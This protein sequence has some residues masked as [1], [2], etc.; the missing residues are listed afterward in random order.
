MSIHL[1]FSN[2]EFGRGRNQGT[3]IHQPCPGFGVLFSFPQLLTNSRFSL[4]P[5]DGLLGW[6]DSLKG[7]MLFHFMSGTRGSSGDC[8]PA[9]AEM[10]PR[11][12]CEH[13]FMME[14]GSQPPVLGPCWG[15]S[16]IKLSHL[17]YFSFISDLNSGNLSPLHSA[18]KG[19]KPLFGLWIETFSPIIT[20]PQIEALEKFVLRTVLKTALVFFSSE[21]R[22]ILKSVRRVLGNAK[23]MK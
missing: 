23:A 3:S 13:V 8:C 20:S 1:G 6:W 10:P 15:P 4:K 11:S 2:E 22:I 19:K 18:L 12:R 21:F 5:E 16:L 17:S 9:N 14:S 7:F